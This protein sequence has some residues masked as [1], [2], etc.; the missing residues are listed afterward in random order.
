MVGVIDTITS[1]LPDA[2]LIGFASGAVVALTVA[3]IRSIARLF[4]RLLRKS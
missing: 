4:I 2:F 1:S 3:A